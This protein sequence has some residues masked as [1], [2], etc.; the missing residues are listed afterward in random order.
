ML[1]EFIFGYLCFL[2]VAAAFMIFTSIAG[3][4]L[5]KKIKASTLKTIYLLAPL[6][7]YLALISVIYL[8]ILS[9]AFG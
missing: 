4:F 8:Y 1:G 9:R 5:K 3:K 6:V 7:L 2:V